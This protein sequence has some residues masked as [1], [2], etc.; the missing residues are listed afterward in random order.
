VN[1][2]S[3]PVESGKLSEFQPTDWPALVLFAEA[4][5]LYKDDVMTLTV[6]LPGQEPVVN[7]IAM[8]N[9]RA[10]QRL[11]AGK[12]T[13]GRLRNGIYVGRFE[14]RRGDVVVLAKEIN[15]EMKE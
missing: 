8:K 6:S 3:W 5:N 11:Y 2:C 1:F 4:I 12:K 14:L 7:S 10:V 13:R 9:N 15:F